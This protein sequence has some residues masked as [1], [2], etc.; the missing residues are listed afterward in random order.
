VRNLEKLAKYDIEF[1]EQPI[2]PGNNKALKWVR[3]R[4]PM[5]VMADESAVKLRDLPGLIGCVDSINIKLM[6]SG[7][8]REAMRMIHFARAAGWKVML[9]CMSETTVSI[10]AAAHL[11]PLVDYV[12]LDGHLLIANDPYEGLGFKAGRHVL[13][14][15]PGLGVRPRES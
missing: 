1:V 13:S 14:D 4:S 11:S 5:P 2:A 15:R 7:G 3:D 12:D 8:I 6:K 9:G 10:T